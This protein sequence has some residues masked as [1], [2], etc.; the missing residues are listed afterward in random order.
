M[1]KRKEAIRFRAMELAVESLLANDSKNFV[2]KGDME[3]VA[4]LD[5]DADPAIRERSDRLIKAISQNQPAL[6]KLIFDQTPDWLLAQIPET[7]KILLRVAFYKI[8]CARVAPKAAFADL[9]D[10]IRY[11]Q[12]EAAFQTLY[13]HAL[14]PVKN[15]EALKKSYLYSSQT[16][17]APDSR[18]PGWRLVRGAWLNASALDAIINKFSRKWRV[19]RLG[20]LELTLLRVGLY[21]MFSG[22]ARPRDAIDDALNMGARFGLD[23]AQFVGGVLDAAAKAKHEGYQPELKF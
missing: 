14:D 2:D 5:E 7:Q 12:S 8:L 18:D 10:F 1:S 11:K 22:E 4:S 21:R 15:I 20:K 6:D 19:E 3:S 13:G 23:S 16:E 9:T 17:K